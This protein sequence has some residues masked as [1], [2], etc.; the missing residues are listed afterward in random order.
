M[1]E[2]ENAHPEVIIPDSPTQRVGGQPLDEFRSV[3][4]SVPMLSIDNTYSVDDLAAWGRRVEKLL[5]E[6]DE[7]AA[8]SIRWVLELKI[9]GVAQ[10][11]TRVSTFMRNI[12]SSQWLRNP[13]LD[14]VETK[15]N[16][17]L[18]ANFTLYADQVAVAD[19]D[20]KAAEAGGKAKGKAKGKKGP[21]E[22]GKVTR[23]AKAEG[24]AK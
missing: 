22:G 15:S 4:H 21:G 8:E 7:H 20:T 6:G 18:G 3:R 12:D 19:D 13:E 23:Q 24:D 17:P 16:Q 1:E 11:S 14:I 10:S 9:D 2:L 5:H